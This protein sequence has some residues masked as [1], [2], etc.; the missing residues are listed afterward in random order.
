MQTQT[1]GAELFVTH[2][3]GS[4]YKVQLTFWRFTAGLPA[5]QQFSV[6]IKSLTNSAPASN[7][8]LTPD[9]FNVISPN[10]AEEHYYSALFTFPSLVDRYELSILF[11]CR[12]VGIL[13]YFG[14][15][16]S[17]YTLAVST[18]FTP[19]VAGI[20]NSNPRF[21]LHPEPFVQA[22]QP[23]VHGPFAYDPDTDSLTFRLDT[24]QTG[25]NGYVAGFL[26]NVPIYY[27][28]FAPYFLQ[29]TH[30]FDPA[31][32][33]FNW[34]PI[35]QTI[36][37]PLHV[38]PTYQHVYTVD[39]WRNGQKI[40]SVTRDFRFIVLN[41]TM[42]ATPP[43]I[44]LNG[45]LHSGTT[46][47]QMNAYAGANFNLNITINDPDPGSKSLVF[48]GM[49]F[50]GSA[51]A[52]TNQNTTS[53]GL[54]ANINWIPPFTMVSNQP[55]MMHLRY[56]ETTPTHSFSR[57]IP[58]MIKVLPSVAA[59]DHDPLSQTK[60]RAYLNESGHLSLYL[61]LPKE[62]ELSVYAYDVQGRKLG[63]LLQGHFGKG[64][65]ESSHHQ[66][67][68]YR[69]MIILRAEDK[70]GWQQTVKLVSR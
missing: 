25:G 68:G 28:M 8:L 42:N 50:Q 58:I 49:M 62:T 5:P 6:H 47:P 7:I 53:T 24:P 65:H 33:T 21:Y 60:F 36:L 52:I 51:P 26:M 41:D 14:N 57:D 67:E 55:H 1:M 66:L 27:P 13:N 34:Y 59:L 61:D 15:Q 37:G 39:E 4:Q 32:G 23:F 31:T 10:L 44:V 45:N 2:V 3:A 56:V 48:T 43:T 12:S 63:V 20:P 11:C 17:N 22:N 54:A 70:R 18:E 29:T 40:G 19:T 64:Q 9:S 16:S 46:L 35:T 30:S 38:Q 69:G